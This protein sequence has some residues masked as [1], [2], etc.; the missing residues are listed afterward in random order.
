MDQ[1]TA[2]FNF[3]QRVANKDL[4]R[5]P[6]NKDEIY[7]ILDLWYARNANGPFDGFVNRGQTPQ[8]S[9]EFHG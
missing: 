8:F 6:D 1:E 2:T 9:Q 5:D 4:D 3:S 7:A